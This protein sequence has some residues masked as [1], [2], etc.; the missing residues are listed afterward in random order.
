[1]LKTLAEMKPGETGSVSSVDAGEGLIQRLDNLGLRT[2][3]RVRRSSGQW[4]SGP[5][6]VI[7]DQR[8]IAL[9]HGA[10][11]KVLIEVD[12]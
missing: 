1:M 12:E 3:K 2:G 9:G 5:V 8:R 10:A 7:V 6:T 4:F 11:R